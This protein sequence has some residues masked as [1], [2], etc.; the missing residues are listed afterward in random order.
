MLRIL[1]MDATPVPDGRVQNPR[2][3]PPDPSRRWLLSDLETPPG[4]FTKSERKYAWWRVMCLTG[5]DYFSTLGYQPGIA[6]LAAVTL[7]GLGS[8]MLLGWWWVQ[9][10]AAFAL[11]IWLVPETREALEANHG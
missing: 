4:A 8:S 10:V 5:V 9:Y 11:L 7:F 6:Y 1:L 2:D 3:S